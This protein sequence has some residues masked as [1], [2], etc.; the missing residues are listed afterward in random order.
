M[1]VEISLDDV[2]YTGKKALSYR[3][4]LEAPD[5]FIQQISNQQTQLDKTLV[6]ETVCNNYKMSDVTFFWYLNGVDRTYAIN[7]LFN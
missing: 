5:C 6:F 4:S 1:V 3:T 2:I 7:G